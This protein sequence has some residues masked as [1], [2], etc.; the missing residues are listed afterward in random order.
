MS[1]GKARLTFYKPTATTG[2]DPLR[3]ED[4]SAQ[5]QVWLHHLSGER[6]AVVLGVFATNAFKCRFRPSAQFSANVAPGWTA[7]D[8]TGREYSVRAVVQNG[9]L[10]DMT[11]ERV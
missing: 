6:A 8:A 7:R 11:L 10:Y 1:I 5:A 3:G 2:L 9:G 4:V